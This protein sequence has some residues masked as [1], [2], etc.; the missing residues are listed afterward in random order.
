[1]GQALSMLLARDAG[2]LIL[3]GNPA[4]PKESRQRLMQ[5][6]GRIVSSLVEIA[7]GEP[8]PEGSVAARAVASGL[9]PAQGGDRAALARLGEELVR[10]TGAV[11]VSVDTAG[12]LPYADVVICATSTT[13]RLVRPERLRRGAVVCDVSRP[14]NVGAEVRSKR[15]DV[16]V[17][18]GGVV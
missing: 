10:R 12:L 4:H 7:G 8:L 18:D 6:A 14:S 17:L 3:L 15:P 2:R 11:S 5:V 1:I 16:L 9:N 13:E